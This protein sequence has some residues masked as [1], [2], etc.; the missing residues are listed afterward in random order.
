MIVPNDADGATLRRHRE[1]LKL[2]PFNTQTKD[3]LAK[4]R[5]NDSNFRYYKSR[6]DVENYEDFTRKI[7][8]EHS[9]FARSFLFQ[10]SC[11]APREPDQ[12]EHKSRDR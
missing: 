2:L 12:T 10:D 1:D 3:V 5:D 6:Y 11:C 9:D 7:E 8:E 4:C